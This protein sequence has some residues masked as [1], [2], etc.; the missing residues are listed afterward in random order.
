MPDNST[1]ASIA[2][3]PI[4]TIELAALRMIV[5]GTAQATAEDFFRSLVRNLSIVTGV[6]NAFIAEFADSKTRVRTLAFWMDGEFVQNQ[7]WELAGTPCEVVL[8]G[9]L[10]HYP[11]NVGLLFPSGGEGVESFLG[12]PLQDADGDI[13]GHLAVFDHRAMPPEPR[14]LYTFQLFA[15]R[16]AAELSRVRAV[17]RL[18]QSEERFRDLFDEAP[19]AYVHEDFQSRFIRANRAAIRI[20]G[21]APEQVPGTVGK[22]FIPDR[23]DAQRRFRDAF[24]SIG[25]GTDTNGVVLELRRQDNGQPIWIQWWSKPDP[26]GQYT[27]TMFIDITDR[28]LME[29]EQARLQAENLYLQDEI[30]SVHNFEEIVGRSAAILSVL[31]NVRRVAVTDASVLIQGESGIGKELIARAVHSASKRCDKPLIKVNCAALPTGLVESE[32]FGHEKGAFTGAIAKRIGR[33]E[34]ADGGTIFLD[35]IGEIPLEVQVKLLRVLQEQEFDRVGGKSPIKVNVRVIAATN[36]NL[37]QEVKDK[38]FREDLYYRLNVFPLTTPPLRE[39]IE[40]IPLLVR[41]MIEKFAVRVGKRVKG[42]GAKSMQRLQSYP[43]PG[44]IRELENVIERA[45]ILA[46]EAIIEIS[47]EMLPGSIG[48][49]DV[50]AGS[51]QGGTL[52]SVEREHIRAVLGQ[53]NWII[54]GP[55]GAARTLDLHPS[56]LRYRM[57]KLGITPD[58]H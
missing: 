54:E 44:N 14:L 26:G 34:L 29:R 42:V 25:R 3:L 16:A 5:E 10:C 36:R 17:E 7:E 24:A 49:A 6:T 51:K 27:R 57:K 38:A 1:P 41:F 45:I 15:A 31:S 50:Q 28:V 52:E 30:K 13:L 12:V 53:A 43:W 48:P 4:D 2:G 35:E 39:R 33:F 23:P 40:D 46:D 19:I 11:E 8:W 56:T 58:R 21:I 32:L 20:L 9:K 37:L 47:P 18:H 55:N 22:S